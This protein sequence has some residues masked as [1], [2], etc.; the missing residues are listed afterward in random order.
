MLVLKRCWRRVVEEV[1]KS[2][3][4]VEL[5][6]LSWQDCAMAIGNGGRR[7]PKLDSQMIWYGLLGLSASRN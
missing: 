6:E 7:E 4:F 1:G 3:I 2:L 5:E